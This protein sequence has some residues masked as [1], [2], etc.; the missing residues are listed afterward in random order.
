MFQRSSSEMQD[1]ENIDPKISKEFSTISMISE[2][3]L[4]FS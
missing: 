1:S 2:D 4:R 3:F